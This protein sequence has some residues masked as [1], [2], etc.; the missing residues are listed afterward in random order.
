M[1]APD[2]LKNGLA[3]RKTCGKSSYLNS[4][5]RVFKNAH[6]PDGR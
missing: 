3:I 6:S 5:K 1:P 4:N 2:G